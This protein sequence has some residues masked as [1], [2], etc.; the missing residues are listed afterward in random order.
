[1][2]TGIDDAQALAIRLAQQE[3]V[4]IKHQFPLHSHMATMNREE[5]MALCKSLRNGMT[6]QQFA[7]ALSTDDVPMSRQQSGYAE[8]ESSSSRDSLR[9][10]IL[11]RYG[12]TV[13]ISTVTVFDV[14]R[15][16]GRA[17]SR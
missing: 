17:K 5:V 16:K 14:G 3:I 12:Y 8:S 6:Q 2:N 4:S 11:E 15:S 1:M 13:E 10:Y 7:E 9:K